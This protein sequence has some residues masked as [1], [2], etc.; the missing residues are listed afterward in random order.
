[1]RIDVHTHYLPEPFRQRLREWN[2]DVRIEDRDGQP[3]VV[4][5]TGSFPLFAGFRDPEARI[6][7]MDENDIDYT[8][9][10]PSTPNPNEGPFSVDQSTELVRA[11]NDGYA[12]VQAAYP[13]RFGGLG[14]LPLRDP[15]AAVEEIGRIEELGLKGVMIPTSVRGRKLSH[16]D[17]EPVFDRL[18]DSGLPVFLHPGRNAL[19]HELNDGEWIFTPM[20]VFPTDTTHQIGRLIFD[21]FFDR[22]DF[23]LVLSHMGG[24]LPYLAGRM[25]RAR[26]QFRDGDDQSPER[27]IQEYIEE[28]YYDTIS[29]HPPAME[30]AIATA[31][32]DN[33]LFG[34]DYPFGMEKIDATIAS[35]D[36]LELSDDDREAVMIGNAAELFD[37]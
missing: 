16:P 26:D 28:F 35:I 23:D 25:E 7:W 19:S 21:G 31:G 9:A 36:A 11:I 3:F 2:E 6:E 37:L 13:D 15:K 5:T 20:T 32:I 34:T 12:D 14:P 27:P 22:H 17:L 18:D 8:L 29:F 10:S 30:A 33:I 1:M 4:H 24:A